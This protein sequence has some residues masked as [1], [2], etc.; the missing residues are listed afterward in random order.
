MQDSI[1]P[2]QLFLDQSIRLAFHLSLD[3]T[4][5]STTSIL[6]YITIDTTPALFS[7]VINIK[8]FFRLGK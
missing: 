4:D 5:L 3:L 8:V 2:L 1:T 7:L 6:L